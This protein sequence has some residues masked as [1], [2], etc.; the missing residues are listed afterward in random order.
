MKKNRMR[1]ERRPTQVLDSSSPAA[2]GRCPAR[3]GRRL[4]K[5]APGLRSSGQ[6]HRL[7]DLADAADLHRERDDLSLRMRSL[8]DMR[9]APSR[10]TSAASSPPTPPQQPPRPS[11]SRPL[12]RPRLPV[13]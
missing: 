6:K 2:A 10:P 11:T 1:G 5:P 8:Q 9:P 13:P 4:P 3:S 7:C 12:A